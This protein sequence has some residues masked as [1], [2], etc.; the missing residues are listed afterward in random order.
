MRKNHRKETAMARKSFH[1]RSARY[2]RP[3]WGEPREASPGAVVAILVTLI[4]TIISAGT[5]NRY[6]FVEA[7]LFPLWY[8]AIGVGIV[9]G[10]LFVLA[11]M[12]RERN[13]GKRVSMFL[14]MSILCFAVAGIMLA[15]VNH[16]F[17]QSEPVR[18][19]VMIED[20]EYRASGKSRHRE[21][22]VTARGDTFDIDVSRRHYKAFDVGDFFVIE[23]HEGALGEP[24]YIAVGGVTEKGDTP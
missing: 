23:Y 16:L 19:T 13:I 5:F 3:E 15:H 24:Y 17:D 9:G 6:T 7:V 22:T 1:T 2:S 20:K 10:G 4:V 14:I 8:V 11:F 21:F 12:R 18:Y